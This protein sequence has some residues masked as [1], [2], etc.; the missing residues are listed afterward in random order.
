MSKTKTGKLTRVKEYSRA[1]E[2]KSG[3][4]KPS[5]RVKEYSRTNGKADR[6]SHERSVSRVI[7]SFINH[8]KSDSDVRDVQEDLGMTENQKNYGFESK[9]DFI[10]YLKNNPEKAKQALYRISLI[11]D[12]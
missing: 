10:N 11:R 5:T 12:F 3:A 7:L 2:K 6:K 8:H 1:G 4:R 9:E